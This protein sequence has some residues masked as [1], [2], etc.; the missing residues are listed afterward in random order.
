M[1]GFR[2]IGD[3]A[4]DVANRQA[5]EALER[6]RLAE[7]ERAN[8]AQEAL[9]AS[10]QKEAARQANMEMRQRQQQLRAG[11]EERKS[12]MALQQGKMAEGARQFDANLGFEQR[13]LDTQTALQ[14]REEQR[15]AAAAEFDLRVKGSEYERYLQAGKIEQE[16]REGMKR[17]F[18]DGFMG[19]LAAT[20]GNLVDSGGRRLGVAPKTAL[21]QFNSAH[22]G[23]DRNAPAMTSFTR[24]PDTGN[25]TFAMKDPASGEERVEALNERDVLG[26]YIESLAARAEAA[27]KN[28]DATLKR[29]ADYGEAVMA[30]TLKTLMETSSRDSRHFYDLEKL[31]VQASA[32]LSQIQEQMAAKASAQGGGTDV[33]VTDAA[34]ILMDRRSAL[35]TAMDALDPVDDKDEVVKMRDKIAGIDRRLEQVSERA[36]AGTGVDMGA[37]AVEAPSAPKGSAVRTPDGKITVTLASGQRRAFP[38]TPATQAMLQKVGISISK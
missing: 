18:A 20:A 9:A 15:R 26:R 28:N 30:M 10:R 16:N 32:R 19:L 36:V 25:V 2:G 17:A 34:K 29:S 4:T 12:E 7:T 24:D 33:K 21:A 6:R 3:D 5:Q 11:L 23:E 22:A 8:R 37:A 14:A 31:G 13:K 1:A 35:Q 38:D 27:T